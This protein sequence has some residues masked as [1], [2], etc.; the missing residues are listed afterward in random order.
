MQEPHHRKTDNLKKQKA[1]PNSK[2]HKK[3][4]PKMRM[5]ESSQQR[6]R[7]FWKWHMTSLNEKEKTVEDSLRN[8]YS[9]NLNKQ[10]KKDIEEPEKDLTQKVQEM[11]PEKEKE[12]T[13]Q[14]ST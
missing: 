4:Q 8:G 1:R 6:K 13:G 2:C 7:E 14:E 12:R 3:P 5:T 10:R 9:N 11:I